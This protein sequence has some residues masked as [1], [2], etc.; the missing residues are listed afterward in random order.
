MKE[1]PP[2]TGQLSWQPEF[3]DIWKMK[4]DGGIGH[5]R[6]DKPTKVDLPQ[7]SKNH[8]RPKQQSGNG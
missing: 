5:E 2:P 4:L 8:D 6:A 1:N 3:A 7:I